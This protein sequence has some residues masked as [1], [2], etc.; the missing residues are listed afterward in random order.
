MNQLPIDAVFENGLFRPVD[1]VRLSVREGERVRLH[2]EDAPGKTSLDE[3]SSVYEGLSPADVAKVEQIALN[4]GHF[5]D[6][7]SAN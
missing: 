6:K 3:A 5:F 1:P 2:I 4:R 7:Q